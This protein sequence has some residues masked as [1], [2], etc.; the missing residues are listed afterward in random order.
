MTEGYIRFFPLTE[1]YCILKGT[2]R[3]MLRTSDARWKG[4]ISTTFGEKGLNIRRGLES[5]WELTGSQ[6]ATIKRYFSGFKDF[7]NTD[8]GREWQ[9]DREGREAF[10]GDTLAEDKLDSLTVEGFKKVISTLWAS[11][12]WRNKEYLT[13]RIIQD[14]GLANTFWF[15]KPAAR[16]LLQCILNISSIRNGHNLVSCRHWLIIVHIACFLTEVA[17]VVRIRA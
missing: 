2:P 15:C 13:S 4:Y 16:H 11:D 6:K 12:F 3:M 5:M 7:L 10:F 9:Q 14:N 1:S 17:R 8:K